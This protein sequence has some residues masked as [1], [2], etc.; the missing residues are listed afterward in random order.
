MFIWFVI[1]FRKVWLLN[2]WTLVIGKRVFCSSSIVNKSSCLF[3]VT[4]VLVDYLWCIYVFV[5]LFFIL[6]VRHVKWVSERKLWTA[7]LF[8]QSVRWHDWFLLP[9]P[10]FTISIH[11]LQEK[12]EKE[13]KHFIEMINYRPPLRNECVNITHRS[14]RHSCSTVN[15]TA[16]RNK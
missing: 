3:T 5:R 13:N 7:G 15:N 12:R 9:S 11:L 4:N 2:K 6:S 14:T 10:L 1:A 16:M 8:Q